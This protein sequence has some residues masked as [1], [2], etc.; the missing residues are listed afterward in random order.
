VRTEAA[1]VDEWIEQL[2]PS[3]DALAKELGPDVRVVRTKPE[4]A[5][6]SF[7][8][9]REGWGFDAADPLACVALE[10]V[11]GRTNMAG[12]QTPY[13]GLRSL[14]G[15]EMGTKLR[16]MEELKQVRL[17]RKDKLAHEAPRPTPKA[18]GSRGLV[19]TSPPTKENRP[20]RMQRP[21]L[22]PRD[23][24]WVAAHPP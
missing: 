2:G 23:R 21:V 6:P 3:L 18:G 11:R 24:E 20:L 13:V 5:Y 9:A 12:A 8:L 10:W 1:A 7:H 14:K 15:C 19:A 4:D 16:A 22:S 17:K